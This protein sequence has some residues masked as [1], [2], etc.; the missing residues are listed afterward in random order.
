MLRK[1][2]KEFRKIYDNNEF[3]I[4]KFFSPIKINILGDHTNYNGGMILP[5]ALD[6]GIYGVARKNDDNIIRL[7]SLNFDSSVSIPVDELELNKNTSW[8]SYALG[9]IKFL[10][11]AGYKIGGMDI[12]TY[13]NIPTESCQT[14]TASLELLIGEM[15]N[16]IYNDGKIE[17]IKLAKIGYQVQNYFE[18]DKAGIMNQLVIATAKKGYATLIDT[19]T[20]DCSLVPCCLDEHSLILMNTK[21]GMELSDELYNTRRAECT[22]ALKELQALGAKIDQLS[23]LPI[24]SLHILDF[25]EDPVLRK[26]AE[27]VVREN[28]RVCKAKLCIENKELDEFG[29]LL[30]ASNESL[31]D[32]YDVTGKCLDSITLHANSFICCL[33][34]RMTG[35]AFGGCALAIV[36][37]EHIDEFIEYV[38]EEYKNDTGLDAEFYI[39][40]T[41]DGVHEVITGK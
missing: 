10:K 23:Q 3:A 25:I 18:M 32:L 29:A 24:E 27:H 38:S 40:N 2:K 14:Y 6:L 30:R 36:H 41:S 13:G 1:L 21:T 35:S 26:R 12:L 7:N 34:A 5:C 39:C 4:R 15:F 37:N 31:K 33:G 20:L 28:D 17:K 16:A 19:N 11:D 9:M 8:E 22:N